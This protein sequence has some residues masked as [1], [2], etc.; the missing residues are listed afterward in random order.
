ME[1]TRLL[2]I[3]M[4]G[5]DVKYM[6]DLLVRLG[7]LHKSTHDTFGSDTYRA[8]IEFQKSQVDAAGKPLEVDGVIGPLTWASIVRKSAGSSSQQ[9]QSDIVIPENISDNAAAAIAW[10]LEDVN[11]VRKKIV[12]EALRHAWDSAKPLKYPLSLYIRG[13]NLYNTDLKPN[14]ITVDR[15]NSG[16]KRQPQYYT[17]PAKSIML[18]AVK[19]NP[20]TTGADCSGGIV[21]L[22]RYAGVVKFSFDAAANNL[23]SGSHS[24]AIEKYQLLPGDW[25][26]KS[27]HIGMYVGGGYVIE[28]AGHK[29]GCQLN[30][31][32]R[33]TIYD[34]TRKKTVNLSGWTKYRRPKYY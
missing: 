24:T 11:A 4:R 22:M 1:Y 30:S 15:I 32:S 29:Y 7:Y 9:P 23:C 25:V 16:A 21:G 26:G 27:G 14:Y 28:W 5:D 3:S 10:A 17:E 13:G 2:K 19:A 34:F 33:R 18:E 6:K 8:V 20:K 31:L 12:L